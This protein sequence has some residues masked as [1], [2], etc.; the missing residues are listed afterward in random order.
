[1]L[2]NED[3]TRL[4]L[5][6]VENSVR[7]ERLLKQPIDVV[8]VTQIA[9]CPFYSAKMLEDPDVELSSLMRMSVGTAVHNHIH[10]SQYEEVSVLYHH[11]DFTIAGRIDAMIPIPEENKIIVIEKKTTTRGKV[12]DYYILQMQ[13]YGTILYRKY[14]I[15]P[16]LYILLLPVVH[17]D[18]KVVRIEF[19]R[20]LAELMEQVMIKR[21]EA[22]IRAR[23][24]NLPT[25]AVAFGCDT[26]KYCKYKAVCPSYRG[27]E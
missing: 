11:D 19:N 22:F 5:A 6:I 26:C 23:S 18:P 1:M 2:G 17:S 20:N 7:S 10:L 12:Y 25:E 14:G 15:M 16:D 21:A 13:F 27:D 4:I 8:Y 24:M 9:R 3:V